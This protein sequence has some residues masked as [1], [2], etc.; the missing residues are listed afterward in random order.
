MKDIAAEANVSRTTVS[1]VLSGRC[2]KDQK[3]SPQV[4]K[5]VRETAEKLGYI[6][7]DLVQGFVKGKSRVLGIISTFP[8]YLMPLVRGYSDEAARHGYSLRLIPLEKD[9]IN[10][11]LM[12]ALRARVEGVAL[13][14]VKERVREK[15][16]RDFFLSKLPVIGLME[17]AKGRTVRFNQEKSAALAVEHFV[18]EGYKKIFCIYDRGEYV[19]KRK[20]GYSHVMKKHHLKEFLFMDEAEENCFE[21]VIAGKPEAVFCGSDYLAARLLQ[22]MSKHFL[23]CPEDFVVAGFGNLMLSRFTSPPL[24]TVEEPY[25]EDAVAGCRNLIHLIRTGESLPKEEVI[26]KLIIRESTQ[27]NIVFNKNKTE[28]DI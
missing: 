13:I 10:K 4:V 25:Y 24:T 27:K 5:K 3:I 11:A 2:E 20:D 15:V 21:K 17:Q 28:T 26:G 8:D 22:E 18:E 12:N 1:F 14:G 9:D 7:N 6:P 16:D 19:L 23:R